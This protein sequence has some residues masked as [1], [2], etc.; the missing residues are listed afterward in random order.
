MEKR[1]R[2]KREK[3]KKRRANGQKVRVRKKISFKK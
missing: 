2:K 1:M 3:R